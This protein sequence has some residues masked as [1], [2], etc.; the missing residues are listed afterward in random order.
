MFSETSLSFSLD[1]AVSRVQT[2]LKTHKLKHFSVKN[3][4]GRG[5]DDDVTV[6]SIVRRIES[7]SM[8][9][10]PVSFSWGKIKAF[11]DKK[12]ENAVMTDSK[13]PS[14]RKTGQDAFLTGGIDDEEGEE[15]L[16]VND[17]NLQSQRLQSA[18][19]DDFQENKNL[20]DGVMS[21]LVTT[22]TASQHA[23]LQSKYPR[24]HSFK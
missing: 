12:T 6:N 3:E 9:G 24:I 11:S 16:F 23:K 20:R 21:Q 17:E 14:E 5:E 8:L 18:N 1:T 2:K 19:A 22:L 10:N 15:Y 4:S 7:D 13:Q